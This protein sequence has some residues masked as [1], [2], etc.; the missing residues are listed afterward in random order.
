[1]KKVIWLIVF[2]LIAGGAYY[3][4]QHYWPSQE[5]VSFNPSQEAVVYLEG[6][7]LDDRQ[8]FL[9]VEGQLLLVSDL[10]EEETSAVF[11]WDQEEETMVITTYDHVYRFQP[12]RDFYTENGRPV[13]VG[14][15][16]QVMNNR[17]YLPMSFLEPLLSI[18]WQFREMD[19]VLVLDEQ[20]LC[21]LWAEVITNSAVIRQ[22]PNIKAPMYQEPVAP[23]D[24]LLVYE[25]YEH[26]LKVRTESGV[27]GY[28]H[29]KDVK[30]YEECR[31]EQR[32]A[33]ES[34]M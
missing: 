10:A 13:D 8:P 32:P 11:F 14:V 6:R 31:P 18:D 20:R 2:L 16:M 28:I 15:P 26:W 29:K 12:E 4:Y 3:G 25:T 23:G 30:R 24:R 1:M 5:R 33:S 17:V 9:V 34:W 22:A 27:I 19:E 7:R 21:R